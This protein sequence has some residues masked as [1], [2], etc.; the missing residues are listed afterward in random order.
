MMQGPELG[1]SQRTVPVNGARWWRRLFAFVGP[2]YMVSVGYMD[3]G[4]WATDIAGGSQFGYKLLW[5]LVL[6][7]LMAIL[8]QTLSARLGLVTGRDLAQACRD[9][10]PLPVRYALFGLTEIAI[11]AT[12]LAEVLGTAIGLNLLFGIPILWAVLITGADV[13]LL[14]AIQ[15]FGIRKMEAMIVALVALIGLCFVIE[16]FLSDPKWSDVAGGLVPRPLSAEELYVAI[17]ILG[18]TVMPHNLYLHSSLVQSRNVHRSLGGVIQAC[19]YNLVDSVVALSGA[20]LVNGAILITAAA[21][22]FVHHKPVTELSEAHG[23]LDGFLGSWL[24]PVAFALALLAAGQSSTVTGTLAGQIT[25]DGFLNLRLRPWL[26]RFL[27]RALAIAPAIAVI[28]LAGRSDDAATGEAG[29]VSAGGNVFWLL[30]LSQVILSLQLPFAVVPLVRF[31]SSRRKMGPFVSPAWA[32]V[33]AWVVAGLI[34]VLNVWLVRE[35]MAGWV[36]ASPVAGW[37]AVGFMIPVG[38]GLAGLLA[39]MTFRREKSD[40]AGAG[41]LVT[42]EE[43]LATARR[44]PKPFRR[45]GVALEAATSDAAML[46]EAVDLASAHHAELVLLHVVEGVGGQWYGPQTGDLESRRDEEYLSAL[47][48]QLRKDLEGQPIAAIRFAIGFG[49]VPRGLIQLVRQEGVDLLVVGGHGHKRLADLIH[50]DTIQSVRHGLG[51]PIL[52]VRGERKS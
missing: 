13:F 7:G 36:R 47:A 17:G 2:A 52:A 30:V 26:Q 46:A 19:R 39:W 15:R 41:R 8:L 23:L 1:E 34:V 35:T 10:Y 38:A 44:A 49:D 21:V 4:N 48:A 33:L 5:V 18:A 12:D 24:A 42:A 20:M 6:S 51:I 32:R 43:V 45:I 40:E 3:P 16:I 14:L 22:F 28:L 29:E 27:T 37:I 9:E 25:M 11:I 50:G 31:T